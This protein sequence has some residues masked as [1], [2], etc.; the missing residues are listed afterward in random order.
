MN[1]RPIRLKLIAVLATMFFCLH[2]PAIS[3]AE[4]QVAT[5]IQA[6][7]KTPI[8]VVGSGTYRKFGFSVY[9]ATLWAADGA[10]DPQKPYALELRY[11]R[12]VSKDTL[13]DTVMDDIRSQN[14]ADNDTLTQWQTTLIGVLPDVNDGDVLTGL[15]LPGKKSLLFLNGKPI[16]TIT[17]TAFSK[18]FFDV[19]L[20]DQADE[21]LRKKLLGQS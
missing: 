2:A 14:V 4:S 6:Q 15:C 20:G 17:D 19:W 7:T 21:D 9:R 16:A 12:N 3:H 13:V 10:W 18:A 8:A 1:I 5:Y 11:L